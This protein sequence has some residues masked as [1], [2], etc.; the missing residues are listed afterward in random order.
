MGKVV[1]EMHSETDSRMDSG[2]DTYNCKMSC[3]TGIHP[4]YLRYPLNV[5]ARCYRKFVEMTY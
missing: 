2:S 4:R 1:G 3:M 5:G